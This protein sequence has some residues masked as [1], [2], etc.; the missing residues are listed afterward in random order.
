MRPRCGS[1]LPTLRSKRGRVCHRHHAGSSVTPSA[2]RTAPKVLHA[3]TWSVIDAV[4]AAPSSSVAASI[5]HM[6][7]SRYGAEVGDGLKP[8]GGWSR[9]CDRRAL[10][11]AGVGLGGVGDRGQLDRQSV[12]RGRAGMAPVVVVCGGNDG[13]G[14]WGVAAYATESGRPRSRSRWKLLARGWWRTVSRFGSRP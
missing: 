5:A 12:P 2:T 6:V 14:G 9:G 3:V 4:N 11:R 1:V 13:E 7:A 10:P 8:W